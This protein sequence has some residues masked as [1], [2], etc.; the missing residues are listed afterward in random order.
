MFQ[1]VCAFVDDSGS[2]MLG[3]VTEIMQLS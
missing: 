1:V 3:H 2:W